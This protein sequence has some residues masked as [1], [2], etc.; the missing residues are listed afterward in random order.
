MVIW[1]ARKSP[2]GKLG[3]HFPTSASH[4][5]ICAGINS[6]NKP[7]SSIAESGKEVGRNWVRIFPTGEIQ[8]QL[9]TQ[10]FMKKPRPRVL[11]TSRTLAK[12]EICR[13][14]QLLPSICN[15]P[16]IN[17]EINPDKVW[18]KRNLVVSFALH[19]ASNVT[20]H[21]SISPELFPL[22]QQWRSM[23]SGHW[24]QRPLL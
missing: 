6:H 19:F 22:L 24:G 1:R 3:P 4:T 21:K 7:F 20:A 11:G 2:S 9:V 14:N 8:L 23:S 18:L 13:Y 12:F 17:R 5:F 16:K 15:I 10:R